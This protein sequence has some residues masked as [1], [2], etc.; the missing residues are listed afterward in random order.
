MPRR[1]LDIKEVTNHALKFQTRCDLKIENLLDASRPCFHRMACR[2]R[3]PIVYSCG[4]TYLPALRFSTNLGI[5][6]LAVEVYYDHC[7]DCFDIAVHLLNPPLVDAVVKN[8]NCIC[9]D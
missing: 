8:M 1:G 4:S 5:T 2:T 6:T 3:S 7:N 9:S